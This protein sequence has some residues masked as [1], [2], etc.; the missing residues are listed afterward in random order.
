MSTRQAKLNDL[1]AVVEVV[2]AAM[3][4][5]PQWNYRF[6]YRDSYPEDHRKF[7]KRLFRLFIDPAIDDWQVMV[8]E[9][10]SI[11]EP[12]V[13]KIV[14]FAVWDISYINKAKHG[15][16]CYQAQS[17]SL[18]RPYTFFLPCWKPRLIF[19]AQLW[20]RSRGPALAAT[21]ILLV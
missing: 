15:S 3:P 12:H 7:T 20:R 10:P 9:A 18:I 21:P 14:A 17:R 5:D 1:D 2:L 19:P 8:A 16:D 6:P 4:L 11:E 13:S